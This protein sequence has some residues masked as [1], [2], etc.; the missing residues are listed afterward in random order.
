MQGTDQKQHRLI[1]MRHGKADW[2]SNVASDFN[3][4]LTPRGEKDISCMGRWL[5]DQ[6]LMP[7][8]F[9]SSPAPR[10]IR[11]AHLVAKELGI[12]ELD[13]MPIEALY[14]ASQTDLL[15][16]LEQHMYGAETLLLI[17]HNPGLENLLYYLTELKNDGD[18]YVKSMATSTIAVLNYG[19]APINTRQHASILEVLMM[20]EEL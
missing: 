12:K 2:E 9:I 19:A 6:G 20:P 8:Q 1:L 18:Q 15:D 16:V 13:V 14:N 5:K 11:S 7:D 4:P 10:A 3:R 17:G